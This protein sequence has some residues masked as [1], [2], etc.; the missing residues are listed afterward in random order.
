[1]G[2][3]QSIITKHCTFTIIISENY[4]LQCQIRDTE[5]FEKIIKIN[6]NQKQYLPM[7]ISFNMN[8]III[9]E[10]AS[11]EFMK[12][13]FLYP[14]EIR[15]YPFIFQNTNYSLLPESL[16]AIIIHQYQKAIGNEYII[17]KTIY[18]LQTTNQV[19]INRLNRSL[20][21]ISMP[22]ISIENQTYFDF[23]KQQKFIDEIIEKHDSYLKYQSILKR[24]S[25]FA[26]I[27]NKF[28]LEF[29]NDCELNEE[30]FMSI[31]SQFTID[32][33]KS[34][35]LTY[36]P[37]EC[38][39]IA[40]K[41]LET[42]TDHVNLVLLSKRCRTNMM[43]YDYN[44]I[45]LTQT[46]REYFP[47][48]QTLYRS[49]R[50]SELFEDDKR[51]TKRVCD[52][53]P[54]YGLRIDQIEQLEKWTKLRC[55]EV[56]FNSVIDKWSRQIST[57]DKKVKGKKQVLF[58]IE[59]IHGEI[60]GYYLNTEVKQ[61]FDAYGRS[62]Q[63]TTDNKS[64]EYNLVSNGRLKKPLKYEIINLE[65]GGHKIYDRSDDRLIQ[66]GNISLYK[67][68]FKEECSSLSQT[69]DIFNYHKVKNP[70]HRRS[71]MRLFSPKRFL[72]IQM[73]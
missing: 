14:K 24:A 48:I 25:E 19:F 12:D 57:F 72:V 62:I 73:N 47:N 5:G 60:F 56:I 8:D 37:T 50:N 31:C 33:K 32:D 45:E 71:E 64:F 21:A 30:K 16:F 43:K 27:E 36:L 15:E 61:T 41:Y 44:P 59:E 46:S 3:N 42:L 13:W 53:I 34:M 4:E 49:S 28:F 6:P 70:L 18:K 52:L 40:S 2:N 67:E 11:F 35:K 55:G 51:I 23:S 54:E 58:L 7:K 69:D 1:M 38:I 39:F 20:H 17:D 63:T 65:L 10:S 66:I 22:G 9:G 29:D 68:E 26:T